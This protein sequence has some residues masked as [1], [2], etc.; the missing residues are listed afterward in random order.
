MLKSK[1]LPTYL[2]THL[3][4]RVK[5]RDA[6]ASKNLTFRNS[7]HM[8]KRKVKRVSSLQASSFTPVTTRTTFITRVFLPVVPMNTSPYSE[9]PDFCSDCTSASYLNPP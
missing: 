2:L 5:S 3:L 4:T 9:L 1:T 8:S 7:G 6:S